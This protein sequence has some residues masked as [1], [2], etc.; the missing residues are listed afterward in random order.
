[1][2]IVVE[3]ITV[4]SFVYGKDG[5]LV[6]TDDLTKEDKQRLGTFILKTVIS[7]CYPGMIKWKDSPATDTLDSTA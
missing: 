7:G 6:S 3:G 2:P 5:E 1:M 4:E